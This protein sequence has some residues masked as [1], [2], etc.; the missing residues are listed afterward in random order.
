MNKQ[1]ASVWTRRG[2]G[3]AIAIPFGKFPE[4][5]NHQ[6]QTVQCSF[7]RRFCHIHAGSR[8]LPRRSWDQA[9]LKISE[10]KIFSVDLYVHLF[11]YLFLGQT[12]QETRWLRGRVLVAAR[13]RVCTSILAVTPSGDVALPCHPRGATCT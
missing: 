6:R 2:G 7:L 5:V 1:T 3:Y 4:V 10:W 9:T 11:I 13:S 8:S 12:L